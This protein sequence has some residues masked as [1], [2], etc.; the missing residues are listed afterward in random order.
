CSSTGTPL[1]IW[2]TL[3]EATEQGRGKIRHWLRRFLFPRACAV[4]VNGQSGCRY[5]QA[6]GV[7]SA[8]L[9]VVPYTTDLAPFLDLE[10][11][12]N[13]TSLRLLYVGQFVERKGLLEFLACLAT[14]ASRNPGRRVEFHLAGE[15]PLRRKISAFPSPDNMTVHFPGAVAYN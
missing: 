6:Y 14:W 7:P 4:L 13:P 12:A 10:R 5:V 9:F 8:K 2:A 11:R 1:V 3:S 15:G